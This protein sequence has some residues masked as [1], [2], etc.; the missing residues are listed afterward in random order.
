MLEE[1]IGEAEIER[2]CGFGGVRSGQEPEQRQSCGCSGEQ[3]AQLTDRSTLADR[4]A[5]LTQASKA[6]YK[7]RAYRGQCHR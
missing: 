4:A 6:Q 3:A 2:T 5:S 1:G 7:H